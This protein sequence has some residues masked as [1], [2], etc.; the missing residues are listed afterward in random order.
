M[1][2]VIEGLKKRQKQLPSKY[3]YDATG[4]RLFQ[5]IMASEDF[6]NFGLNG[7]IPTLI[8]WL[9]AVDAADLAKSKQTGMPLPSLHSSLFAPVPEPTIRTG[10]K[11]MPLFR[12]AH[13]DVRLEEWAPG[14]AIEVDPD[15]GLEVLVLAGGFADHAAG[16]LAIIPIGAVGA[17]LILAGTDLAVSR[18][19]FDGKPSCWW[20]IGVTALMTVTVNP[21]LG[22]IL[23]WM[24]E[25]IRAAVV[26]RLLL[27]R[28]K[29]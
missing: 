17:L 21:A 7:Q 12:D 2:D 19:L 28:R 16:L 11:A 27:G 10:V 14:A 8:F 23:G 24:T 6:G 5:P 25:F 22:L 13:E 26:R 1:E 4:D 29:A 3:F 20:V 15:G 9:G 18:R